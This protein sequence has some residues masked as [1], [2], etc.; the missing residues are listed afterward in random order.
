VEM[1][2]PL[3]HPPAVLRDLTADQLEYERLIAAFLRAR[4]GSLG[5]RIGNRL[6]RMLRG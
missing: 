3:I 4:R 2:R 5:K 1:A 6:K